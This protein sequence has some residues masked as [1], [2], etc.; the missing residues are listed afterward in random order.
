MKKFSK[1]LVILLLG[2]FLLIPLG[3]Y[4]DDVDAVLELPKK[5][6]SVTAI[7]NQAN[8]ITGVKILYYEATEGTLHFSNSL[9]SELDIQTKRSFMETALKCTKES[10]LG[11]QNK[12]KVFNF[13][14]EQDGAVS[15]A[16]KY[17]ATD[18]SADLASAK[19]WF[20]PISHPIATIIGFICLLIFLCLGFSIVVDIAY[21][22][23]PPARTI[24][25]KDDP[26]VKPRF[27]SNCAWKAVREGEQPESKKTPMGIYI[28]KRFIEML[29]VSLALGLIISGKLYQILSYFIDAFN[30]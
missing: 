17:L 18:T 13:I 3:V 25:E 24:F 16:L 19:E 11:T 29:L 9:Y 2:V 5:A 15:S 26:N 4:A 20:S 27:I 1:L 7:C 30:I 23:I 22:V 10:S 6:G 28:G 21:I 12:N 14:A 8:K